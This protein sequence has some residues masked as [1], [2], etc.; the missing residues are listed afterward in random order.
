MKIGLSF[1]P[2]IRALLI[3]SP[4]PEQ[5]AAIPAE[6]RVALVGGGWIAQE[7]QE[8]AAQTTAAWNREHNDDDTHSTIHATGTISERSRTVPMGEWIDIPLTQSRFTGSGTMTWT[9]PAAVSVQMYA[10]YML[11]G[12]TVFVRWNVIGMS[13]G[14]AV[15]LFL[16][17]TI[18]DSLT[19]ATNR[20]TIGNFQYTDNGVVGVGQVSAQ[21][22]ANGVGTFLRFINAT[23]V[24]WTASA[25][26][27]NSQGE[28]FF[29]VA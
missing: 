3:Q 6:E 13:V 29:E 10:N 24:N 4:S 20:Q 11:I 2:Q 1:M 17:L 28:L 27:N 23:V 15:G 12:K 8:L 19:P 14:G 18:L 25:G 21:P 26:L 9:L 16:N 22:G 5:L 7:F